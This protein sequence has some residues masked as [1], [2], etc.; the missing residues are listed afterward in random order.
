MCLIPR[1]R[2]TLLATVIAACLVSLLGIG[3]ASAPAATTVISSGATAISVGTVHDCAVLEGG[4][5]RCWWDHTIGSVWTAPSV[6]VLGDGTATR[7]T[8]PVAVSGLDNATSI[9]ANG[10]GPSP[11]EG[12]HT[13][14]LLVDGMVKCWGGNVSGQLG[15][16]SKTNSPIPVVVSSLNGATA[17]SAGG[18]YTCAL[19][20]GG[21]A[22][23]WGRNWGGQLGDGTTTDRTTPV[24]VSGLS[25]ATAISAGG[26]HTCAVL[27]DGTAKCWG[28][29]EHGKLGDGTEVTRTAPVTVSGLSGA[30]AIS[31]SSSHTCAILSDGT[32]KCWGLNHNPGRL[33]DGTETTRTVPVPVSGLNNATAISA[34]S[35]HTCALLNDGSAKCWG[36]NDHGQLGDGSKT[37][38]LTPVPVSGLNDAIAISAGYHR[39]CALLSGGALE[40]W[41]MSY[42]PR[43][44]PSTHPPTV[45]AAKITSHPRRETANRQ[46]VFAFT[47][48]PGGSYECSVDAGRWKPCTSGA[49]FGP[50][51]P[52]DHRFRVRETLAG[53]TG[54]ADSYSWTI[55]LPRACILKWAR[56][57]VSIPAHQNKARL[58][59]HYKAYKPARVT[60]SYALKGRKGSLRLGT[61]SARFKTLGFYRRGKRLGKG[62][63]AKLRATKSMTVRFSI[64]QAPAKCNRYYTKRLTISHRPR[65]DLTVWFQSDSVFG[66]GW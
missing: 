4:T 55:V 12:P 20:A 34:G 37:N 42:G 58:V 51:P 46:A 1:R 7:S 18:L 13:C 62:G 56:A 19:L 36:E 43:E 57:R 47:G 41:G 60:V 14:A 27:N 3:A 15:D 65:P 11:S 24:P 59:I 63:V 28:G 53:L 25:G 16:G 44:A 22:S 17:V 32:A 6:G 54:P 23:C 9:S 50:L 40:C 49:D 33:G 5:A 66:V 30:T 10:G 64:P 48:E 61:A 31:A 21:T 26:V 38:S 29:N 45:P 8:T 2:Q 35:T 52:G 39:T